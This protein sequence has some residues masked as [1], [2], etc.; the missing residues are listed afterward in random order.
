MTIRSVDDFGHFSYYVT[1]YGVATMRQN[2]A[3]KIF[4]VFRTKLWCGF[5]AAIFFAQIK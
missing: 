3:R 2:F 1:I 4:G 5:Y